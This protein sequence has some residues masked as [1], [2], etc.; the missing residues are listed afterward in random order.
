MKINRKQAVLSGALIVCGLLISAALLRAKPIEVAI[1]TQGRMAQTV[2]TSG[3]IA[4]LARTDVASQTTARIES[5]AV[6]E[7]DQVQAGQILVKLRDDEA[8]AA[9][10]QANA[11]VAEA[12]LRIRQIQT[13]QSPVTDQQLLQAR[14]N[15]QQ[16]VQELARAQDLLRQGFVSQS[17]LDEALR[18][19]HTT[20]AAMLAATA[21]AQ[22]N[23]A[24]G[25]EQALA[26]ARLQQALAAQGAARARQIGRASCR[27]RG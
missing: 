18:A 19:T 6:R 27:E 16:A 5:I 22:G 13:I 1:V 2:V 20:L 21:Q 26:Q 25:A 12:D 11:T 17:R 3:R 4:T 9:L 24:G 15:H 7:G 14:A 10:R 8:Q 23:Q